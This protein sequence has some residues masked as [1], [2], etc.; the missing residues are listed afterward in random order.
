MS[1]GAQLLLVLAV[2]YLSACLKWVDRR[3]VVFASGWGRRWRAAVA[4]YRFG[5]GSGSVMLLN[6]L[7]P[8][9]FY[10]PARPL[11]LSISPRRIVACNFQSFGNCGRPRQSRRVAEIAADT[12]FAR[13]GTTLAV[14]GKFFCNFE[15][16]TTA[17]RITQL[18]NSVKG[19]DESAR[20]KIIER[21]WRDRLD[22]G[23]A[24]RTIR[25]ALA[26]VS[27]LRLFNSLGVLLIFCFL[28][29]SAFRF[30]LGIAV[31]AGAAILLVWGVFN[32][33]ACYLQHRRFYPLLKPELGSDIF[34]MA[35]CPLTA[36]RCCDVISKKIA[37]A[38]DPLPVA[39]LLL[40]GEERQSFIT[41]YRKDLEEMEFPAAF[42]DPLRETCLWQQQAIL[43]V[44]ARLW[45]QHT[46]KMV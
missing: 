41:A 14:N 25:S 26:A 28:P 24:K 21:F 19:R 44:G 42:P 32:C 13:H 37:A 17:H 38:L 5:N 18:L 46:G 43:R 20:A 8:L 40:R 11:P 35:L 6:P 36:L 34:K 31:L 29:W 33:T 45:H 10:L 4:D 15:D 7:P 3:M 12:Q 39:V 9:G 23:N 22:L 27:G 16:V 30:G 1:D 2:I